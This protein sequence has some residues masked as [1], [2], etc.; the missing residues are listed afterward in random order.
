[1]L[2]LIDWSHELI[3]PEVS[4][5]IIALSTEPAYPIHPLVVPLSFIVRAIFPFI[6]TQSHPLIVRKLSLV[7]LSILPYIFS[8]PVLHASFELPL[9]N[10][11]TP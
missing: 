7:H 3:V 9:I 10:F 6:D 5:D 2:G 8:I 4:Y 11:S 1:M